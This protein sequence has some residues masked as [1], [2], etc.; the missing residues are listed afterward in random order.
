M[1][2]SL[3]NAFD[4]YQEYIGEHM[5]KI[6]LTNKKMVNYVESSADTTIDA[7]ARYKKN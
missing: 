2:N 4:K 3:I 6:I 7:K 5:D 1:Y